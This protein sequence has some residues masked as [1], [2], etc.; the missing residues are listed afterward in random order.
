[1]I[2]DLA[3]H[4]PEKEDGGI[5]NPHFHVMTTMRPLNP[6]G[7]WGQKQRREYLLD[8]DGNRIR[9]KNGDYMFN[10]VHTTDS[11]SY[12]HLDVYK[13]QVVQWEMYVEVKVT[14]TGRGISESNQAAIFRR[15]YREEEV[16]DQQGVGIGLYLA[17]EIVTRQGGY[18]KVVSELGQGSEFSIMLPVR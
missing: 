18:I 12:T 14:D 4:N 16:H 3:F 8:E 11:V 15:F 6:D 13:R 17:R 7:T 10:A 2:V 1:M 9:D 5:P